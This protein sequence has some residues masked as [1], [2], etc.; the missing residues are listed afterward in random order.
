VER[1]LTLHKRHDAVLQAA[2]RMPIVSDLSTHRI[3][4][5]LSE[6]GHQ[7]RTGCCHLMWIV[8]PV[9]MQRH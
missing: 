9:A 8:N 7:P 3:Y 5:S 2:G 6:R 1:P 4:R